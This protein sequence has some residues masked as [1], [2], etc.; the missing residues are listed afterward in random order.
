METQIFFVLALMFGAAL[1][2]SIVARRP[3]ALQL[4]GSEIPAA[5]PQA[6]PPEPRFPRSAQR[7]Y[8]SSIYPRNIDDKY[9]HVI[10]F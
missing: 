10:L 4:L 5:P 6:S 8:L 9:N 2:T 1:I 7:L 3:S